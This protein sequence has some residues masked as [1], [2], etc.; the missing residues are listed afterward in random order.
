MLSIQNKSS[1]SKYLLF[2]AVNVI[3]FMFW[4]C[5]KVID[6]YKFIVLGALYE[7]SSVFFLLLTFALPVIFIIRWFKNKRGSGIRHLTLVLFS[8]FNMVFMMCFPLL[9]K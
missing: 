6:I 3:V 1:K 9:Y 2:W 7:M 8:V 5:T 4:L